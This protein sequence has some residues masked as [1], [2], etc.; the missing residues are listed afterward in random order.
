MRGYA[1][2]T[3]QIQLSFDSPLRTYV[4]DL[5]TDWFNDLNDLIDRIEECCEEE[6]DDEEEPDDLAGGSYFQRN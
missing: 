3:C 1:G 5:R 4:F 6:D 2:F